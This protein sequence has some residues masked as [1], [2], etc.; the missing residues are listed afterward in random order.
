MDKFKNYFVKT[1]YGVHMVVGKDG[2]DEVWEAEYI[3]A[4]DVQDAFHACEYD[5]VS[6]ILDIMKENIAWARSGDMREFTF[7]YYSLLMHLILY[8]NVGYIS[9]DFIE[10]T[11]NLDGAF[12]VQLW[13]QVWDSSYHLFDSVSFFQ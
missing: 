11:S 13:T 1:I 8:R 7:P 2:F 5:Y 6:H 4:R 3:I 10:Q 9:P 12:S